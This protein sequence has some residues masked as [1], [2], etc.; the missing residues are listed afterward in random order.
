[1]KYYKPNNNNLSTDK[2]AVT[3]PFNILF[4][5]FKKKVSTEL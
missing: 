1:M 2:K 3:L 5:Y 4:L